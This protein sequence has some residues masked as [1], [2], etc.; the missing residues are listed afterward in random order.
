MTR[1]N[2]KKRK[3]IDKDSTEEA[4]PTKTDDGNS[5]QEEEEEEKASQPG[6]GVSSRSVSPGCLKVLTGLQELQTLQAKLTSGVTLQPNVFQS[7]VL[8]LGIEVLKREENQRDQEKRIRKLEGEVSMLKMAVAKATKEN[9][10]NQK[11]IHLME[12]AKAQTQF[13]I[14][15]I[16][17]DHPIDDI[18]EDLA[19]V[20]ELDPDCFVQTTRLGISDEMKER[21]KDRKEKLIRPLQVSCRDRNDVNTIF[22][23]LG[24]LKDSL[25]ERVRVSISVPPSLR[26]EYVRLEKKGFEERMRG[27]A[28]GVRISSNVR[29]DGAEIKLFTKKEG[30]TRYTVKNV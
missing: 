5:D 24:N 25:F 21:K 27:K 7:V 17:E 8:R 13:I 20:L 2:R 18:M 14:K 12:V 30:E 28:S 9:E 29:W 16:S 10:A 3:R 6:S 15:D 19:T 11:R 26:E 1:K 23:R 4:S 22:S